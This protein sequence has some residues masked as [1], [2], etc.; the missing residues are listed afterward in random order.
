MLTH[1]VGSRTAG[2]AGESDLDTEDDW[3]RA[4]VIAR[5]PPVEATRIVLAPPFQGGRDRLMSELQDAS[6]LVTGGTGSFGKAFIRH[7]LEHLQPAPD[8]HPVAR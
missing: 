8:R 7:A 1:A 3:A 4:E 6:I 2:L 5:S